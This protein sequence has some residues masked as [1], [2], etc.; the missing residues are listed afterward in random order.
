MFGQL[1]TT[2]THKHAHDTNTD[3]SPCDQRA[4][5]IGDKNITKFIPVNNFISPYNVEEQQ[6]ESSLYILHGLTKRLI[7]C[8][9]YAEFYT[10]QQF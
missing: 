5:V 10:M 8:P 6:Y 3:L 7:Q 1:W 9:F 2:K 4:A